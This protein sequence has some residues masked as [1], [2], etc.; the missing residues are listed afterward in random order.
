MIC[1]QED[2]GNT[3]YED[4]LKEH[5]VS[6]YHPTS[7]VGKK[8]QHAGLAY[9]C[10]IMQHT[11]VRVRVRGFN[12]LSVCKPCLFTYSSLQ[13]PLLFTKLVYETSKLVY[14]SSF[15]NLMVYVN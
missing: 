4:V 15:V 14:E 12:I 11:G 9:F 13:T 5:K 8:V 1:P 10:E 7:S 2:E 3:G 6:L